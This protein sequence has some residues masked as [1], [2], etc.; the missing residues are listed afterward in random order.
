MID[1]SP[2]FLVYSNLFYLLPASVLLYKSYKDFLK[3]N[4]EFSLILAVGLVSATHHW[5]DTPAISRCL[6]HKYSLYMLDLLFSYFTIAVTFSPFLGDKFR[7]VYHIHVIL[8]PIVLLLTLRNNIIAPVILMAIGIVCFI[9]SQMKG[10]LKNWKAHWELIPAIGFLIGALIFKF[11]SDKLESYEYDYVWAHS[12][13]HIFGA[14]A[15]TVLFFDL[16][17]LDP[18]KY[19]QINLTTNNLT[20]TSSIDI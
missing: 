4:L 15:A 6:T 13:W 5:C 12:L 10:W 18:F 20:K 8:T 7:A 14:L 11:K 19:Q 1:L 9:I 17:F 16:P 2:W 3:W